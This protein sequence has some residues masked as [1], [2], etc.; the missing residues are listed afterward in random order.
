MPLNW[1][2]VSPAIRSI[3]T[4]TLPLAA[5]DLPPGTRA[6]DWVVLA[7][8]AHIERGIGPGTAFW[9]IQAG[10]G[11]WA[12]TSPSITAGSG[13]RHITLFALGKASELVFPCTLT[14]SGP[15]RA[16]ECHQIIKLF[17]FRGDYALGGSGERP[18]YNATGG[19]PTG[20]APYVMDRW[21]STTW[22]GPTSGFPSVPD[23]PDPVKPV[24]WVYMAVADNNADA[25]K[26]IVILRGHVD[27]GRE[28]NDP[29]FFVPPLS[30][31]WATAADRTGGP[32]P[33]TGLAPTYAP[34]SSSSNDS[35]VWFGL[36][37]ASAWPVDPPT[38]PSAL[39]G[40]GFLV[41]AP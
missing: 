4:T 23:L 17:T 28:V 7:G 39:S 21:Y 38:L 9:S 8:A 27:H 2:G 15:V 20:V 31:R 41:S 29:G 26:S 22:T 3:G 32:Q 36:P 25:L 12:R 5:T 14:L 6:D 30:V 1:V 33:R 10:K 19:Y 11:W 37:S 13:G 16:S 24:A 18:V 34:E 40:L 35:S